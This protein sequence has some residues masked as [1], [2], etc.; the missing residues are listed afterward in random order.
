MTDGVVEIGQEGLII[1]YHYRLP[2]IS[3]ANVVGRQTPVQ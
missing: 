1:F 3:Q 2:K